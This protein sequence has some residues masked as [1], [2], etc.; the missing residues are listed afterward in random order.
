MLN[1]R[2]LYR[3]LTEPISAFRALGETI[4]TPHGPLIFQDN[5]AKVLAVA[6]L[7]SVDTSRPRLSKG[8]VRCPQLDDRLGAWIVLDVLPRLG[9][10]CDILLTDSEEKGQSTA[11][12]FTETDRYNWVCE[13]DR[14][15]SDVVLYDYE[16]E[17]L[18]DLLESYGF[19]IGWGS[20]S[21]ICSLRLDVSAINFGVGYH[22]QHT[23][24]CFAD[25]RETESMLRRF[26]RF[27]SDQKGK[28]LEHNPAGYADD[29]DEYSKWEWEHLAHQY[30]YTD[31]DE[32][33]EVWAEYENNLV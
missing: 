2:N 32:F 15:G 16:T 4:D 27:Y 3:R 19:P 9:V 14:E 25:L 10:N 29:S 6:H 22:R 20:F 8:I 31:V 11:Q 23:P 12:Y 5:G 33:R 21:D 28:R 13:F 18:S 24:H 26:A 30:G 1:T 7:D 17:P